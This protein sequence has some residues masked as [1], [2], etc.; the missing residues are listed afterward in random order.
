MRVIPDGR[1]LRRLRE[2][3]GISMVELERISAKLNAEQRM[4]AA[5]VPPPPETPQLEPPTR[6][7]AQL[8]GTHEEELE[9]TIQ[10]F[11]ARV[12]IATP[13]PVP[14]ASSS[15]EEV[16]IP[17]FPSGT[18][19]NAVRQTPLPPAAEPSQPEVEPATVRVDASAVA[20]AVAAATNVEETGAVTQ[21]IAAPVLQKLRQTT[22]EPV[23]SQP[24]PTTK[25]TTSAIPP[26]AVAGLGAALDDS[27]RPQDSASFGDIEAPVPT[28]PSAGQRSAHGRTSDVSS[29]NDLVSIPIVAPGALV[30]SEEQAPEDSGSLHESGD[31]PMTF[32]G[33]AAEHASGGASRGERISV[34]PGRKDR[35][36]ALPGRGPGM[37]ALPGRKDRISALP[38]RPGSIPDTPAAAFEAPEPKA[39]APP[40]Q[41]PAQVH[42]PGPKTSGDENATGVRPL[43]APV[44]WRV[45]RTAP[46]ASRVN[47]PQGSGQNLETAPADNSRMYY[48]V[49]VMV[50]LIIVGVLVIARLAKPS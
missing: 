46:G 42:I 4:Q 20:A 31:R 45:R 12:A 48:A 29:A 25:P 16:T 5:S 41:T 40:K 14:V 19:A 37:S 11:P 9:A 13:T 8:P 1:A 18:L 6:P 28:D 50:V 38:G 32:A 35:I 36:S 27:S 21:R 7:T 22:A 49:A 30:K 15:S 2:S 43:K 39:P 3:R 10:K 23:A 34:L 26:E 17:K 24:A 47:G 44:P 33:R